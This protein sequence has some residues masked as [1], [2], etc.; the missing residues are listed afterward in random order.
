MVRL[1]LL[2]ASLPWAAAAPARA[3]ERALMKNW[4]LSRCLAQGL[5]DPAAKKDAMNSAAGFLEHGRLPVES[6]TA[7]DPLIAQYAMR[8]DTG[9]AGGTFVTYQCIELHQSQK[10]DQMVTRLLRAAPR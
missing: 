9:P 2:C 10:L 3:S 5:T 8:G 6:Y 7:L 4:A 1:V